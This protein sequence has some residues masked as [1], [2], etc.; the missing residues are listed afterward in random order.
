[1]DF[2]TLQHALAPTGS[3]VTISTD[4]LPAPFPDLLRR[5]YAGQGRQI[6]ISNG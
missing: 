5:Y 6:V 3:T 1:M 4:T 2:T